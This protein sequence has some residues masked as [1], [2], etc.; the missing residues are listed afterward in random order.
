ME[1]MD[2]N[3]IA[4]RI[5]TLRE[6]LMSVENQIERALNENPARVR[7][8]ETEKA[9]LE[10]ELSELEEALEDIDQI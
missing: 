9:R 2:K 6:S 1:G 10:K 4:F 7:S 8:L 3:V 5:E